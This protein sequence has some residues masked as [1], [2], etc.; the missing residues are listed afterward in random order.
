LDHP[1]ITVFLH[2]DRLLGPDAARAVADSMKRGKLVLI[3]RRRVHWGGYSQI[4]CELALLKV[5]FS[6]GFDRYHL[7]SGKD[8]LLRPA[9]EVLA[10]FDARGDREFVHFSCEEAT[11]DIRERFAVYH[12]FQEMLSRS[13]LLEKIE[14]RLVRVQTRLGV[15]RA[16]KDSHTFAKGANWFSI[17]GALAKKVLE[18]EK[19]IRRRFRCTRCCDE[20]FLQSIVLSSS[21][22][23]YLFN[24][25]FSDDYRGIMR[26]IDWDR[27]QPY[28]FREG[29]E[30]ELLGSE[31]MFA[32][33]FDEVAFPDLVRAVFA[34]TC[35]GESIEI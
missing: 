6:Y 15:D 7:L 18:E 10:F 22:R 1:D 21:F 4:R 11:P 8:L 27:G 14:W 17:T 20:V 28:T 32:R 33:K 29:D 25:S 3:P 30:A 16:R 23:E 24:K 12:P 19:W 34:R 35:P 2:L 5:A 26:L 9:G 31:M 13:R